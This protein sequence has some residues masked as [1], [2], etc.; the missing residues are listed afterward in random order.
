ML[1]PASFSLFQALLCA[2]FAAPAAAADDY[3]NRP[4]RLIVPFAPGGGTD[5]NARILSDPIG[6]TLGQTIVIDNRPGAGS[7]IGSDIAAKSVPDGYTLLL[8]T[9][10]LTINP[11]VYK[12]LP[13]D[14]QRDLIPITQVSDQP[15]ILVVHPSLPAKTFQD[16]IALARAQS[17][18]VT[19]G[20]AG[21]G[22]GSHLATT[23]LMLNINAE[24]IHVPFK[25]TGPALNALLSNEL[26][27]YMSTFA[28]ALPHVKSERL[29][30]YAVTTSYRAG[31]L[32]DVPTLQESGMKD[33][34]YA[35]WYGMFAP[36]GTPRHIIDKVYKATVG[37][38]ESPMVKRLYIEQGLNAKPNTPAQ[39]AE[40]MA[41]E[42]KKWA[43]VVRRAN[44]QQL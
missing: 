30:P 16:F 13:F 26:T 4:I 42:K 28:S 34:E 22:T 35:A 20:S 41:S 6:K 15:S 23:L 31:P 38:L 2:S 40:Y 3:P 10:S 36:A 8:G 17:G 19:F 12:K 1:R 24:G 37:A 39:F 18:K 5:I 7:S 25:G 11:A 29:R 43:S 27:I 14:A 33:F 32:P 21:H 44:I 9:I